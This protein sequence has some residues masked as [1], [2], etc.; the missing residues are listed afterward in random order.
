VAD[1]REPQIWTFDF[2]GETIPIPSWCNRV[3]AIPLGKGGNGHAGTLPTFNGEAGLPGK[4]APV[5]WARDTDFTDGTLV[6]FNVLSDG[7][8]KLSIP[9]HDTAASPGVDG[10]GAK[11][12]LTPIGRGPGILD[13]N[14][15]KYTGGVDQ[16][17]GGGAGQ[18]PGGAGN[19]GNGLFFQA[20]GLGG[21]AAGWVCFRQIEVVSEQT[22]GDTTPPP[23]PGVVVDSATFSTIIVHATGGMDV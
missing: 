3:D 16:K 22:E 17:A 12:N 23:P 19:G 15:Q 10:P 7:S 2:D 14:G 1:H 20:G 11:F 6:T 21:I 13:Y 4:F 18:N 9:S 5:T 8:A